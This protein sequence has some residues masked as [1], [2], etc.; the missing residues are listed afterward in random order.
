MINVLIHLSFFSSWSSDGC[1]IEQ[2]NKTHTICQ[3]NH[4]TNFAIL[5]DVM[6]MQQMSLLSIIDE[7][8][9]VLIFI[10]ITICIIFILLALVTLK[11]FN[12]YFVKVGRQGQD[13]MTYD[14][15]TRHESEIRHNNEN[16]GRVATT[17][18]GSTFD[19]TV[20]GTLGGT[21]VGVAVPAS[22]WNNSL[23][24]NNNINNSITNNLRPFPANIQQQQNNLNISR[25]NKLRQQQNVSYGDDN[26]AIVTA[27]AII[28][29][30]TTLAT[31]QQQQQQQSLN[32]YNRFGMGGNN[33]ISNRP[34]YNNLNIVQ[35]LPTST[36]NN[37]DNQTLVIATTTTITASHQRENMNLREFPI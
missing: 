24:V 6:D 32:D 16:A 28:S 19:T 31:I 7:N 8:I 11:L 33:S 14:D 12:G 13:P 3:C 27:S 36:T 15:I 2:T 23:N 10:S 1:F 34:N 37:F 17:S 18:L 20:T 26:G 29:N 21:M 25:N 9:R 4:L 22:R 30:I 35:P 5:M